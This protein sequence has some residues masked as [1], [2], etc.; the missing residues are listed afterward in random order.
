MRTKIARRAQRPGK[1]PTGTVRARRATEAPASPQDVLNAYENALRQ[2]RRGRFAVD[3]PAA[4]DAVLQAL[5]NEITAL[6]TG[7]EQQFDA[8]GRL[9]RISADINAG[10]F[11][12]E[13]LEH[14]YDSFRGVIPYD[15]IGCA[16]IDR[17]DMHVRTRWARAEAPQVCNVDGYAQP[18]AGSSLEQIVR[19]G[20]PRI[21]NDL[22]QYLAEH[23]SSESTRMIVEEGMRAS[24]TCPLV[25]RG[26][27]I[28]FVFFS[29]R[30]AGAYSAQ[31]ADTLQQV[32]DQL[33]I[34]VEKSLLYEHV[35]QLNAELLETQHKLEHLALHDP[36]TGLPN[37]RAV[38]A[39]LDRETARARRTRRNFGV[40]MLDLDHFKQVNDA[41]GHQA[42]DAVLRAA[43][44]V[45]ASCV[46]GDECVGR[47][48]GEEF[49]AIVSVQ[50]E[51][52]LHAAAERIRAAVAACEV[53]WHDASLRLTVSVGAVL[54]TSSG[55]L[56]A[57]D[58]I[59]AADAGLY[60]AKAAGRNCVA[61]APVK[62][63]H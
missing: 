1:R 49:L 18:L 29:S 50:R 62:T 12:E 27:P 10:I 56:E 8:L 34:V 47:F 54:A 15:R 36:L 52:Q 60:A 23:P 63:T 43:G 46:R 25:S 58:L 26:V 61:C 2:I 38:L 51:D 53:S 11:L 44:S 48:G 16:I 7:L 19:T 39:A 35:H 31:H 21:L 55:S 41:H 37:R 30:Q 33:S 3:V 6:A 9:Q 42:G 20:R 22:P 28:G 17:P 13:I 24:L 45:L 14:V 57:D 59:A 40:L 4:R 32:A 5:G